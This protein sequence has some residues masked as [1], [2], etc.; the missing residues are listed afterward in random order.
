MIYIYIFSPFSLIVSV[1]AYGSVC[2]F[3]CIV[4]L[5]QFVLG[6]FLSVFLLLFVCF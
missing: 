5:L 2:D 6:L 4:L 3:V 1:Y